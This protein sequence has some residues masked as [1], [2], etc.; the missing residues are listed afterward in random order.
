MEHKCFILSA[1]F[2]KAKDKIKV[3]TDIS[4]QWLLYPVSGFGCDLKAMQTNVSAIIRYPD[5][6]KNVGYVLRE[7]IF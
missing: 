3:V 7:A 4:W 6:V 1:V 5:T 2:S